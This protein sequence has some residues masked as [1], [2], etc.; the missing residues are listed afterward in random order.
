MGV[1]AVNKE[2]GFVF[3]L[4]A[5]LLFG[6]VLSLAIV[7]AGDDWSHASDNQVVW[8]TVSWTWSDISE[9]VGQVIE[10]E[11]YPGSSIASVSDT[12]PP[13]AGYNIS[14]GLEEYQ[15]FVNEV[16]SPNGTQI[17]FS[18]D[19]AAAEAGISLNIEGYNTSIDYLYED[20]AKRVLSIICDDVEMN[21]DAIACI[22]VTNRLSLPFKFDPADSANQGKF[23]WTPKPSHCDHD[24]DDHCVKFT[25]T[26]FDSLGRV[27]RCP[28]SGPGVTCDVDS[29][30]WEGPDKG[31]LTVDIASVKPTSYTLILGNDGGRE[32]LYDISMKDNTGNT[33][34]IIETETSFC[35]D[36][37]SFSFNYDADLNV[38]I[39]AYEVSRSEP[40]NLL[41]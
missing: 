15:A 16:Y 27:Y 2:K 23:K 36:A 3:T 40:V 14:A 13:S 19:L 34:G 26:V 7:V 30:T 11:I 18:T 9:G 24:V 39:P 10:L 25:L 35:I 1:G 6:V 31:T 4:T 33:T 8:K 21:C 5:L 41:G 37:P 20:W 38:S 29:F 28:W 12:L 22:N 17:N 32:L